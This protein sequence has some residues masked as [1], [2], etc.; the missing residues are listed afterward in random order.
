MDPV[1]SKLSEENNVLKFTVNGINVSFANAIRR[2]ILSEIPTLVFRTTPHEKCL[3]TFDINTSRLNNE[4]V[5]QRLSCIPIHVT[6]VDFPYKD[7]Q[8][9]VNKKNE[10]DAIDY[11]TTADFKVKNISTGA[12][13][14]KAETEKMFPPNRLT[15][16]YI[17]F[18][19]LRPRISPEI[20]GEQLKM[21]CLLDVG[22]AQQDSSFNITATCSYGNTPDPVKIKDEWTKKSTELNK[23][24]TTASEIEFLRKDWL[25]LDAKRL[26]IADS[27]DFTLET[28]GPFNN[29]AIV[30]K[31]VNIMLKK[32]IKFKNTMETEQG[33]VSKTSTTIENGF[34]ITIPNEGYTLGKA[35]EFV[36]YNNHYGKSLTYCGFIKPHPHIDMCKIRL[37]FKENMDVANVISY[38]TNAADEAI[39]VFEKLN[40]IFTEK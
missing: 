33:L 12:Y 24:G 11:V 35:I 6:D 28:V 14:P 1:V 32:L 19:R 31:A 20:D 37:G 15:G 4:L 9:E 3:A 13:L 38:L 23:S 2:I 8:I 40:I 7:Y 30:Y 17:D 16:D 25:L 10:S 26:T 5:K 36:L 22:T 39:K 27:F 34:D 18:V 21:S 29:M